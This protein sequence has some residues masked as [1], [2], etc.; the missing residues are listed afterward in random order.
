MSP[1]FLSILYGSCESL[2]SML[3]ARTG[4]PVEIYLH[5]NARGVLQSACSLLAQSLPFCKTIQVLKS[6]QGQVTSQVLVVAVNGLTAGVD[7]A[8]QHI[9]EVEDV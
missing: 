8:T 3:I 1:S 9:S 7:K 4:V 6:E 2:F 5:F